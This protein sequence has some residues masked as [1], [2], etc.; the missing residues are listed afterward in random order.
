MVFFWKLPGE[1]ACDILLKEMLE[2]THAVWKDCK[3]NL[4]DSG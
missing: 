1:R 3:Q 2:W 4:T